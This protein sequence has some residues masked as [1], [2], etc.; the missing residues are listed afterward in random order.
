MISHYL[1]YIYFKSPSPLCLD[2]CAISD[3]TTIH[4]ITQAHQREVDKIRIQLAEAMDDLKRDEEIFAEK[5]KELKTS[6]KRIKLLENQNKDLVDSLSLME[7][8]L[9]RSEGIYM[10][11]ND[12]IHSLIYHI[13]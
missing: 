11:F 12:I 2:P 8:R 1:I 5:I 9:K 10:P 4:E 6:R 13:L 3:H 7:K